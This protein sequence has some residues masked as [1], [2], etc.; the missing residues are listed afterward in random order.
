MIAVRVYVDA[1]WVFLIVE[2]RGQPGRQL[3]HQ[4][5]AVDRPTPDHR[6]VQRH[7]RRT[8]LTFRAAGTSVGRGDAGAAHGIRRCDDPASVARRGR[9]HL[10]RLACRTGGARPVEWSATGRTAS[11]T[12]RPQ[13]EK[14]F[15]ERGW[16]VPQTVG[17]RVRDWV[18]DRLG[19]YQTI[20]DSARLILHG[21]VL[22]I[23]LYVL[24]LSGA[25]VA[26]HGGRVLPPRG[27]HRTISSVSSHGFSARI[28][29]RS[30]TASPTRSRWC[31]T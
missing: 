6:V 15:S 8:V 28:L 5:Q 7:S 25:G 20:A 21:G 14:R 1:L 22:A 18:R 10:R 13:A 2:F 29:C 27:Q 30:G 17:E 16:R 24:G 11:S 19:N 26:G 4:P 23:S 3:P 12:A 9:D 31:R